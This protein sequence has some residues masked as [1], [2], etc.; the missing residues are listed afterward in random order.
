MVYTTAKQRGTRNPNPLLRPQFAG[1]IEYFT[2]E[3]FH[4]FPDSIV[5]NG[6]TKTINDKI[7]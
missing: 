6:P 1:T 7:N 4:G 2:K 5:K 3:Y